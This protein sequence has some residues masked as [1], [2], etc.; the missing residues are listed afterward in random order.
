MQQ[1]QSES[2]F[3]IDRPFIHL[4]K[5]FLPLPSNPSSPI[6]GRKSLDE[7]PIDERVSNITGHR[8]HAQQ[9]EAELERS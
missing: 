4:S 7:K 8:D 9:L 5:R 6:V 2:N 3:T 1:A